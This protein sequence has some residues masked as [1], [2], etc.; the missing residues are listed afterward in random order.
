M[1]TEFKYSPY[2]PF[3]QE[4]IQYSTFLLPHLFPNEFTG[5]RDEQLSW[6][7]TAYI[8]AG[9]NPSP[10]FRFSGPDATKFLSKYCVNTFEK[11]P[12]GSVKHCICCNEDGTIAGDG[13]ILVHY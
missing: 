12:A 3:Y 11:F 4:Q 9:L 2:L 7:K 1:L 5:W 8:S 6:K 10:I 13:V